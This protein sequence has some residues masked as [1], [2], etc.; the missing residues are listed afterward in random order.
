MIKDNKNN[1]RYTRE[2]KD[3]LTA[4]L[5]PPENCSPSALS[6]ETGISKSTLATWKSKAERGN[7]YDKRTLSSREKFIMVLETY[8]M[9][10]AELS[11]YCREKGIFTED[12]KK[13]RL[14]CVDANGAETADTKELKQEMQQDKKKIK[15]LEKELSRKEKALAET[16]TLLVL[17]K[18]LSAILGETEE[19]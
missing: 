15:S 8:T 7:T 13:W 11:R 10:E 19:D 4:R 18:K 1:N 16:A 17:R 2:E 5:L 9:S 3:K 12:I 6:S 14:S